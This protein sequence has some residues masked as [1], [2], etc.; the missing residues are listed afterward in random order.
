M[1][2]ETTTSKWKAYT[3]KHQK[4]PRIAVVFE[5]KP[6]LIARIKKL[7]GALWSQSLGLWHLPDTPSTGSALG[8]RPSSC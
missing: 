3:I 6:E 7:E 5:K 4:K 8:Y 2:S 1:K